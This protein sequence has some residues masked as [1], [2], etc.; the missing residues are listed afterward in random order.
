MNRD[1]DR[2]ILMMCI[3]GLGYLV[4]LWAHEA[5]YRSDARCQHIAKLKT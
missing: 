4:G 5:E 3:F 2:I 1:I